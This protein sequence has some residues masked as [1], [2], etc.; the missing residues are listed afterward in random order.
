MSIAV[1]P[2]SSI[3]ARIPAN[4]PGRT[5]TKA[6]VGPFGQTL[7]FGQGLAVPLTARILTT[8]TF[9]LLLLLAFQ[10]FQ[11][12]MIPLTNCFNLTAISIFSL[13]G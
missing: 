7:F 10:L 6:M 2:G 9:V 3:T 8:R 5:L 11:A 13:D 1:G 4:A 12:R